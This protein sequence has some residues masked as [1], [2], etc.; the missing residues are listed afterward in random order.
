MSITRIF[1]KASYARIISNTRVAEWK[2]A[3]QA[4]SPLKRLRAKQLLELAEQDPLTSFVEELAQLVLIEVT[5]RGA[6]KYEFTFMDGNN[7]KILYNKRKRRSLHGKESYKKSIGQ[8]QKI[9]DFLGGILGNDRNK[10]L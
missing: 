8:L 3:T 4:K 1:K 9:F 10:K 7:K 6:K 2:S 5:V